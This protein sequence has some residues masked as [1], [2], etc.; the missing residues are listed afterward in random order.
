MFENKGEG[1]EK[2]RFGELCTLTRG[3]NPPKSKFIPEPKEGYVRFYQ[4][5]DGWSDDYTVYVPETPQL[6]KVEPDEILMVAYRHIGKVFR[7]VSC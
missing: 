7:G 1:W 3:H 5:R 4:I 6:H 2:K